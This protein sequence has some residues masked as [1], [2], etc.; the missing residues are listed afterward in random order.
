MASSAR[1]SNAAAVP[2]PV[3]SWLTVVTAYHLCDAAMTQQLAPLGIKLPEHEVLSHVLR[4]PGI[5]QQALAARCFTAKSHISGLVA[6]LEERGWL[7]RERDPAD[8]RAR[9]LSLTAAGR[10]MAE[11]SVA[12]QA[13][14]V[15]TMAEAVSAEELLLVE[16]AMARVNERLR[17]L[18][19]EG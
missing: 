11:R 12:V 19:A 7:L 16:Q 8:G 2:K 10:T 9:R 17:A 6:S 5:S 13:F 18:L 14:I 4:D 3:R 1:T 15:K